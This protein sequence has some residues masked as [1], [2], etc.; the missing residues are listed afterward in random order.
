MLFRSGPNPTQPGTVT[1][2]VNAID[3]TEMEVSDFVRV[4]YKRLG[5]SEEKFRAWAKVSTTKETRAQK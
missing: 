5:K 4:S 3:P 2:T 1:L